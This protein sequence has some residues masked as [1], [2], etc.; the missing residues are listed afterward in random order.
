[1]SDATQNAEPADRPAGRFVAFSYPSYR[2]YW[3][4]RFLMAFSS[5][6]VAVS[7]G[8]QLYDLTRD[9][10]DLGLVGLSQF[11]PSLVLVLVTGAVAD[12]FGRRLVMGLAILL[13][14]IM[15]AGLFGL[16]WHGLT[17]PVQIFALMI[18]LGIARAFIGP[19]SS[20]LVVSLVAPRHFANAVAFNSSSW[21]VAMVVGPVAGGLA[22]GLSPLVAY[23]AAVILFALASALVFSIPKPDGPPRKVGRTASDI[24]AG[25]TYV[26]REKVV[27]G[28]ISLDLFAVLLGGAVALLPVFARDILDVGPLGLGMLRAAPGIGAVATALFLASVPIRDHAGLIMFVCVALFGAFTALFGL[29]SVAWLSIAALIG[30]GAADMVSVYIRETVI[31]L[32]TPDAV[33]GRVNAVNMLFVG[34]SNEVG[35][36]RAGTMGA[37]IGVVPAVVF[38][39]LAAIGIA[40]C[41]AA[42]FPALRKIRHL[43]AV[44]DH[45]KTTG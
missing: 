7:V 44:P 21:Q 30:L 18:G 42:L 38:G 2:K 10:L 27:L 39:G 37:L 9:P 4:A 23:G 25:F 19:A 3:L 1:M 6:M 11:A 26:F 22:Y 41:W 31:Q 45:L 13:S 17:A 12:R 20:A 43:D 16:T 29:S 8:W 33:R 34:A 14:T 24:F 15:A 5:Q 28:A 32:W 40:G 36:F 35:E